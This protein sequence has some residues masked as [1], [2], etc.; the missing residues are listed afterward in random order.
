MSSSSENNNNAQQQHPSSSNDQA[1]QGQGLVGGFMDRMFGSFMDRQRLD[2]LEQCRDIEYCLQDCLQAKSSGTKV[3]DDNFGMED[4]SSGIRM[5]RY[6]Q[7]RDNT[8]KVKNDSDKMDTQQEEKSEKP[9]VI[10]S[11]AKQQHSLWGCRSVALACGVDLVNLRTCFLQYDKD[12]VLAVG[13]TNYDGSN[14][15]PDMGKPP[16]PCREQQRLL[17]ECITRNAAELEQRLQKRRQK[18]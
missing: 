12:Q 2:R 8:D 9:A 15:V 10:P 18:K 1:R 7:W 3:Q 5:L 11:C 4:I 13:D 17:G 6:Y 14:N 16:I